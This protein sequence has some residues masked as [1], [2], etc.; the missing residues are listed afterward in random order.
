MTVPTIHSVPLYNRVLS[1]NHDNSKLE[2]STYNK[3]L[4]SNNILVPPLSRQTS[5]NS[6]INNENHNINNNNNVIHSYRTL[7]TNKPYIVSKQLN[8]NNSIINNQ[9]KHDIVTSTNKSSRL[10]EI[11]TSILLN[12][13]KNQLNASKQNRQ[14]NTDNTNN[15]NNQIP[16]NKQHNKKSVELS[17]NTDNDKVN[18]LYADLTTANTQ[19]KQ[20][21]QQQPYRSKRHDIY[22]GQFNAPS[23]TLDAKQMW[24]NMQND[25]DKMFNKNKDKQNNSNSNNDHNIHSNATQYDNTHTTTYTTPYKKYSNMSIAELKNELIQRNISI[26][27]CIEKNDLIRRLVN[28]FQSPL[29]IKKQYNK[30]NKRNDDTTQDNQTQLTQQEEQ[31]INNEIQQWSKTHNNNIITMLNNLIRQQKQYQINDLLIN[32]SSYDDVNKSYKK[33]LLLNH[34]DKLYDKSLEDKY[35]ANEIIKCINHALTLYKQKMKIK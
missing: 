23:S 22:N 11:E 2:N 28:G 27:N 14:H 7:N 4:Y 12:K 17:N 15:N 1:T 16:Y 32:T 30:T 3:P 10:T 34:P 24:L 8:T 13:I 19:S 35:R 20:Q 29:D 21:Q 18:K 26:D 5:T 33:V 6:N 25:I 31:L 9:T